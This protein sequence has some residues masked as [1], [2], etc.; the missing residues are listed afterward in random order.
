MKGIQIL[1]D[2]KE[3]V[4]KPLQGLNKMLGKTKELAGR[5]R[6]FVIAPRVSTES[7][8]MVDRLN[9]SLG[10]LKKYLV[11]G[12]IAAS[13]FAVGNNAV[14]AL[15]QVEKFQVVLTKT[16]GNKDI[17]AGALQGL[18]D[19][20][21]K[22]NFTSDELID[23]Y[24]KLANRGLRPVEKNLTAIG[25]V[26]NVLG[27]DFSQVNEAI[28]DISNSERWKELGIQ[29]EKVGDKVNLTFRGVT[30][31]VAATEKGVLEAITAF[32]QMNG[33]L[34]VTAEI[35]ETTGGKLSTLQDGLARI[36]TTIGKELQPEINAL[37]DILSSLVATIKDVV[38]WISA[39][40]DLIG[41]LAIIV[42]VAVTAWGAYL[43]VVN[44]AAIAQAA[45]NLALSLNPIG[46]VIVAITALVA[47]IVIAWEKSEQFRG[48]ILGLW[49][50]AK[51]VFS[52]IWEAGKKYLGGLAQLISGILTMNPDQIKAGLKNAFGGLKDF[53][54][55][56]GKGVAESFNKG[57]LDGAQQVR[58][59]ESSRQVGEKQKGFF[60][61]EGEAKF[62]AQNKKKKSKAES[63][64]NSVV[65]EARNQRNIT[66]SIG[67]V[68]QA[69]KIEVIANSV[70]EFMNASQF[71]KAFEES[72]YRALRNFEQGA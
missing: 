11:G 18:N 58:V 47:A 68:K 72:L 66:V 8:G 44:A 71:D 70:K 6:S 67:V 38:L 43:L 32:G 30:H 63:R 9:D 28:L 7:L 45:L 54:A 10:G 55:G 61:T 49:E 31:S 17:A 62:T 20:A 34:G 48:T 19:M 64:L 39:N 13:F 22:T 2:L 52:N 60:S 14:D 21:D 24:T 27:K 12:A 65:G 57:Y 59:A 33:V 3:R 16:L 4:A 26:A 23:N 41:E 46:I 51:T 1:I 15:A 53:Y 69:D 37:I 35:G 25:D 5:L 50:A 42:G 40:R 29:S 56:A 36:Y